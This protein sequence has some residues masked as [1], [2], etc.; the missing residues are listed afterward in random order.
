MRLSGK[1]EYYY[2]KHLSYWGL[3]SL[4]TGHQY[5]DYTQK[6]VSQPEKFHIDYMLPPKSIKA[7]IAKTVLSYFKWLSP[8]YIWLVKKE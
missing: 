3:K 5:E 1:G 8:G 2:E 7:K 4:I 6:L